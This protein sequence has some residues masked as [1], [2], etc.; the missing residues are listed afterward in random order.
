[1]SDPHVQARV[2]TEDTNDKNLILLGLGCSICTA[3][4]ALFGQV[5]NTRFSISMRYVLLQAW[6]VPKDLPTN[7]D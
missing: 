7:L 2:E 6:S 4:R 1:M 3:C 5:G